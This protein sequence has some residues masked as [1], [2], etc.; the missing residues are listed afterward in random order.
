[1]IATGI[2][3]IVT[4]VDTDQLDPVFLGRRFDRT[5]LQALPI[6][7]NRYAQNGDPYRGRRR[8]DVRGPAGRRGRRRSSIVAGSS[9]STRCACL[10]GRSERTCLR[11][12]A[13]VMYFF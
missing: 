11:G 4:C 8:A 10:A 3:A 2:E 13:L 6:G 7:V 12:L 1:M 5:L 9:L